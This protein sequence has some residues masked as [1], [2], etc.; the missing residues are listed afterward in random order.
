MNIVTMLAAAAALAGYDGTNPVVKS[1]FTPDPAPVVDGDWLYVFTGH[2]EPDARGYH[3][4]DWQVFGTTN[5]TDW[6]DFGI[7]M[8]TSTFKWAR[9]GDKAWAS[10]A[11]RR[12]GKWYWYVAVQDGKTGRDAIGVATADSVEG[13]WTDPIGRSVVGDGWGFIDPSVFID[14]DGKA[15]LFWGNCGG[16]PGCWY[17]ELKDNMVECAGEIKPVPG[18]MDESAFGKPLK[19]ARGAG[20]RKPIDTNFE[21]APWI[22]KLG[23]TYYLE[24]AAG[25]VPEHWAYS[26][27]KSVH[28]P[29]TY[30][31]RIMD[32]P[33]NT[34]TIHG[35]SVFFKGQWYM[36]YHNANLPNG[37]DCRRS[38]CVERYERGADGSIPYIPQTKAGISVHGTIEPTL[39]ADVP[40]IAMCRKGGKYY[41]V[42]TTM[43]FNPG[44]P[45]MVSDNLADWR[46]A[47]YCYATV[48]NR[49]KDRLEN[50]ESDYMFGT[51]A[52]SIRYDEKTD[53][54]YVTSFN[55]KVDATY[56]F[57]CK[58]PE[59][60]GWEFFRLQPKQYDESLWI[61]DGRFWVYAT[62]PGRPYKVRL[63][64]M[65]GDFS[66]FVDGGEIVLDNVT[67]CAGGSGLGEGSQV[68]K[69][70]GMYYLVNIG[71]PRGKCRTVIVH[72][73]RTM[74]GPWEGKIVFQ[75]EGIAQGS[76][77]DSPDG[78]WYAY[79]FGDRGAVGR[80]PYML[81]VEWRDGWPVVK[82]EGCLHPTKGGIPGVV[83]SDEFGEKALGPVWQWNHNPADALWSLSEREGWM[84]LRTDRT[85]ASLDMA[86]NS[87]T[88]RC[89][90]PTC[91]ATTKVDV[92]ALN[93]GDC[94]GLALFQREYVEAA[95]TKE[96]EDFFVVLRH[97]PQGKVREIARV[98]LPKG[99]SE[100]YLKA[101]GDFTRLP[102]AD[103]RGNPP[104]SD[105]GRFFYS[106]DGQTWLPIGRSIG[107]VYTIPHFTGYRFALFMYSTKA[108]GGHADF[109]YLR[110]D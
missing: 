23:D 18:L 93:D 94:A 24:Y 33:E 107:L 15:Y 110:L 61:E 101:T 106:A 74:K 82:A 81:P 108:P 7:V 41:M 25:G 5:M 20:A 8:D 49:P 69:H 35:G 57:R 39:W 91:R 104:G 64:E 85:D 54:F 45:V 27:A 66:G 102:G 95:V 62:V 100:V 83:A 96:G 10:Q 19:K 109:D 29:W 88:Q 59:K 63:T 92:S 11:I 4:K 51:W 40:D 43:H 44:I 89:W 52:S 90:G 103:F 9:Q 71:W 55:N 68:F 78:K 26:T 48:E 16:N 72:R 31:G 77:I 53:C 47:S 86:R 46:I 87:L 58:D 14:D 36:F 56:F 21:E 98:K 76:F 97:A 60:G 50:G 32:E 37:A 99:V 38:F 3:M 6:V 67:D 13:P 1:R 75:H 65:K 73:S 28:G 80:C 22:Y 2:D 42:S 105:L 79:L 12:D 84:R 70:D 17:V 30:R 34:G